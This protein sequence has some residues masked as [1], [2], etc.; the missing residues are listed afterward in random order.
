MPS[1]IVLIGP[2]GVGKSTQGQ[3]LAE[4]LTLPQCSM[5]K[6]RWD[7]YKEIG[8][9]DAIAKQKRE[10]EGAW[11]II[12]Y[13][14]PF[15]AHA[16]ERLLADHRN[17]VIDFGAGH[18]VYE[19]PHL[20]Q[21]VKQALAPYPNVVLLLPSSDLEESL[22]ILNERNKEL[23]DDIRRTNEHF[24]RHPSNYELAKITVYTKDKTPDQT[25]EQILGAI[26]KPY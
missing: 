25:C 15:E 11:G 6:L 18:S 13:W 22:R 17:C 9:D 8:Y 4:R 2:I 16:V 1:D 7:Y 23:P 3:L 26:S 10:A 14:K 21:R 5:D 24:V 20:F 12:R 19:D